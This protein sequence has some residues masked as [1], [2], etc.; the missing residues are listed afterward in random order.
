MHVRAADLR[1]PD[2]PPGASAHAADVLDPGAVAEAV[3]G[4]DCV[5]H[6]AGLAHVFD[7]SKGRE[8]FTAVNEAGTRNVAR[9]AAAAGV[10]HLVLTSSVS[11]YGG[12]RGGACGEDSPCR[13]RGAY[14][15]SKYRAELRAGQVAR[16]SGLHVTVLRLATLYGEGDPGNVARL[17]RA[18]DRG[19]FARVGRGTNRKSLLHRDDAARACLTAL[20]SPASRGRTYNVSAPPHTMREVLETIARHLGR[21]L[22]GRVIPG[23][24]VLG[25]A[26]LG[27]VLCLGRGP[28]GSLFRT[29]RKWLADDVY[30]AD[31]IRAELG[32]EAQ[33]P[34][35]DGLRR[36]V[37]WYRGL[38]PGP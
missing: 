14:A 19:R 31:R 10:E 20:R 1:A 32:F 29:V 18:I 3:A 34:L 2:A 36:E 15:E 23:W 35:D 16:A 4:A 13:P 38:R 33:V 12:C 21:P 17:V 5:V 37:E 6:A 28:A 26:G 30:P 8:E 9:A 27:A 22:S 25:A 24:L 11:V 7:K